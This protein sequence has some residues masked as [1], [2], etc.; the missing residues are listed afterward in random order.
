MYSQLRDAPPAPGDYSASLHLA[1]PHAHHSHHQQPIHTEE[2]SKPGSFGGLRRP[3]LNNLP[4]LHLLNPPM[5]PPGLSSSASSATSA[6]SA[7]NNLLT[8]PTFESAATATSST[9]PEA[10]SI[11]PSSSFPNNSSM[12]YWAA[13]S[14][15]RYVAEP[16][17]VA[18]ADVVFVY[19]VTI[20]AAVV[21]IDRVVTL[22][23][24]IIC[25]CSCWQQFSRS[26][27]PTNRS[28]VIPIATGTI[29]TAAI[30]NITAA[31]R[32][33]DFYLFG[34]DFFHPLPV[35]LPTVIP[36]VITATAT[37]VLLRHISAMAISSA[38]ESAVRTRATTVAYFAPLV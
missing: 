10:Y 20:L 15:A 19:V 29:V 5:S 2:D 35:R 18:S 4:S 1:A 37:T 26:I 27:L 25:R 12:S 21:V 17:R 24:V 34:A 8:P 3:Y 23:D 30:I 38:D 9:A 7:T 31:T 13:A 33:L 32:S 16:G 22:C 11:A 14:S 36:P 6:G 28:V